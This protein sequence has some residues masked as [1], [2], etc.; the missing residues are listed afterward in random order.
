ME[1]LLKLWHAQ[2]E[3]QTR[4]LKQVSRT[5][6]QKALEDIISQVDLKNAYTKEIGVLER[7]IQR[8]STSS[9]TPLSEL[10]QRR[11]EI[12]SKR[13]QLE[14]VIGEK[15]G[16]L[17]IQGQS[18]LRSLLSSRFLQV[19]LNAR[20]LKLRIRAKLVGRKFELERL[21][22]ATY[23]T[24][25]GERGLQSHIQSQ[26]QRHEPNITNLVKRYND[27][28][29]EMAQL[30]QSKQAPR[31]SLLPKQIDRNGLFS[32]DIDDKIWD[33]VGLGD[34]EEVP[35]WMGD[36]KVRMGIQQLLVFQRCMEEEERL[37][38]EYWNMVRWL[39]TEWQQVCNAL[40]ICGMRFYFLSLAFENSQPHFI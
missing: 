28:C 21:E 24:S 30:V 2:V 12:L 35:L 1:N 31:G 23:S 8:G 33:D 5:S 38:A 22:R 9:D 4:P 20:A 10:V 17:G 6:A 7:K 26:I 39:N 16:D 32:M 14:V 3:Y 40:D 11:D 15:K 37:E 18:R 13:E 27:L 19:R 36:E 34:D 29:I 25:S